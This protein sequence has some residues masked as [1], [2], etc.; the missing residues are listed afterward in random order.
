MPLE[1]ERMNEISVDVLSEAVRHY[2]A[3]ITNSYAIRSE[4]K[5]AKGIIHY[6]FIP[7]DTSPLLGTLLRL[8]HYMG[9][10]Y[11]KYKF[12]D[13]GCGIGNIALLAS[14]I[15]F[16][17]YGLE[18]NEKIYNI[19]KGVMG[20]SRVFKGDMTSF[21]GYDKY[22]VLYYY[23]PMANTEAMAKFVKRLAKEIKCGAYVIPYTS[24]WPFYK[25]TDRF[26]AVKLPG[27]NTTYYNHCP[28]Y[29][30]EKD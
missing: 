21:K 5:S 9:G 8:Y 1:K 17:A 23:S 12:L 7:A 13:I 24:G 15:G 25:S 14:G 3:F 18:Y 22:D 6:G 26:K 28:I 2:I 4:Y 16:N 10:E 29:R 30:K 19:A 11:R 27:S 20:G